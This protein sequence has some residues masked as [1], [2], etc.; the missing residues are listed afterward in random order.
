MS[1][2]DARSAF[3]RYSNAAAPLINHKFLAEPVPVRAQVRDEKGKTVTVDFRVQ[4]LA[5]V[6]V[7]PH[8]YVVWNVAG[9]GFVP[10]FQHFAGSQIVLAVFAQIANS[11][12]GRNLFGSGCAGLG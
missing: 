9:R 6:V 1:L 12:S 4:L 8:R 5:D 7:H 10:M 11:P 2:Y 3:K